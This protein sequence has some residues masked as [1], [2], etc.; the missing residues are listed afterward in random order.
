MKSRAMA[1]ADQGDN[2]ADDNGNDLEQLQQKHHEDL[3]R[4]E[5]LFRRQQTEKRQAHMAM[6]AG[7][8]LQFH[9][10]HGDQATHQLA[11]G[12]LV[13]QGPDHLKGI[14]K[15]LWQHGAQP[16]AKIL[17]DHAASVQSGQ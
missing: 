17:L 5:L 11:K 1:M 12:L 3:T 10:Q 6:Q 2:D 15:H 14:G 7:K 13:A 16:T 4:R 8:I 9:S